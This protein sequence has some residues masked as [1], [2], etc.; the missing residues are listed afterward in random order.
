MIGDNLLAGDYMERLVKLVSVDETIFRK[1]LVMG[2]VG[3]MG[4]SAVNGLLKMELSSS[5][6]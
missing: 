2:L 3:I 6:I 5:V 1:P 4:L